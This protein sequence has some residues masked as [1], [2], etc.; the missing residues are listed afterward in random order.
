MKTKKILDACCG[1]RMFYFDQNNHE[2]LFNDIRDGE[3]ED[4]DGRITFVHPDTQHDFKH[5]PFD[6]RT[7]CH[8]VFDPPH[9]LASGRSKGLDI[10]NRYGGLP[11]NWAEELQKGLLEC[12]RVLKNN[13]TLVFKWSEHD[14]TV[15]DLMKL[16]IYPTGL[17]PLYGHRTTTKKTTVWMVFVKTK[18][19]RRKS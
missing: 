6:D 15:N 2:V 5:L 3:F 14:I 4:R 1:S 7:F 18:R 13:G 16:V 19:E 10:M 17:K 12:Y 11:D 9:L 8:V